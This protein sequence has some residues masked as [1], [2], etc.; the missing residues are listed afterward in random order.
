MVMSNTSRK[1][2][3]DRAFLE[4]TSHCNFNCNFCTNAFMHRPRGV[5]SS[6]TFTRLV[7][8]IVTH[9]LSDTIFFHLMGE[10]LLHP[11][12]MALLR[13]AVERTKQQHL[14][15][16]GSLFTA[17]TIKECYE[18]QLTHLS[19]SY[20]TPNPRLFELRHANN[21]SFPQYHQTIQEIVQCKFDH[22]FDTHLRLF[23]P[24]INLQSFNW[25]GKPF[26]FQNKEVIT[27]IVH[28]WADFV[29][30]LGIHP[31]RIRHDAI[32]NWNR[33]RRFSVFVTDDFEIVIKPFHNWHNSHQAVKKAP[34][35]K[36]SLVLNHEQLGILWNGDVVLCCG[37][38][39]GETKYGN[40]HTQTLT[41][42]LNSEEYH[43][44]ITQFSK[45]KIPFDTCQQCLG[46]PSL[47]SVMWNAMGTYY[48]QALVAKFGL[49][50]SAR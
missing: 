12:I 14:V 7:D 2:R 21:M 20:F 23:Y 28:E 35:G 36:C 29:A 48:A 46:A 10:P 45:G 44:I 33:K 5:M 41:E 24:N 17:A 3:F 50:A 8:E 38:Y 32:R 18:T 34:I 19:I 31:R 4:V 9:R 6:A 40:I 43:T 47:S 49:G 42:V 27:E 11:E 39:N 26:E 37:D 22:H 15:T 13:Y 30:E 16:N 1:P 25:E